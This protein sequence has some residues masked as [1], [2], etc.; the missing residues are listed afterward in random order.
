MALKALVRNAL[1]TPRGGDIFRRWVIS[2]VI[3]DSLDGL[4]L[5]LTFKF[6]NEAMAANFG[7]PLLSQEL[8][9]NPPVHPGGSIT[10]PP[11]P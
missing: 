9:G 2:A 1:P 6:Y 4:Q 8:V 10:P 7:G 11:P 5:E 3:N